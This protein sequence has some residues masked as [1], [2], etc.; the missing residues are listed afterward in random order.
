VRYCATRFCFFS[1]STEIDMVF[2]PVL[3]LGP[4]FTRSGMGF[5]SA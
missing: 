2:F 5:F 1:V 3:R 4:C